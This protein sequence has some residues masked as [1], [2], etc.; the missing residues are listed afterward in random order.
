MSPIDTYLDYLRDV[1]RMAPN[2]LSNYAR[3]L[4]TLD[5]Y[6]AKTSKRV[7]TLDRRDLEA[8]ARQLMTGGLAPRSVGRTIACV[9]GFYKFLLLE[10]KIAAN[11]AEDL[12]APR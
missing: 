3:D 11:P 6:A 8:F 12:H 4:H 2:T 7:E 1:R 10:K 5:G 9:R